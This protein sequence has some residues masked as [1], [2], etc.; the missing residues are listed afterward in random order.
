MSRL[1]LFKPVLGK[2]VAS[3]PSSQCA[4]STLS[5]VNLLLLHWYGERTPNNMD[6]RVDRLNNYAHAVCT[7]LWC[8]CVCV[9]VHALE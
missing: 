8:V 9:C 7:Y 2:R 5:E 6:I 4:V 1:D 3:N